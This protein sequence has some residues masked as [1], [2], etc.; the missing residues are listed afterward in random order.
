M[1]TFALAP[2]K[3][4]AN[5][6]APQQRK[7]MRASGSAFIFYTI[8]SCHGRVARVDVLHRSIFALA[9]VLSL[10]GPWHV[11]DPSSSL[12]KVEGA[13]FQLNGHV[14]GRK[15]RLVIEDHPLAVRG[16]KQRHVD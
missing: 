7:S 3:L 5:A 11:R 13:H 2:I 12:R 1:T 6:R 15:H 16:T 9:P 8:K 14:P 4:H 10:S